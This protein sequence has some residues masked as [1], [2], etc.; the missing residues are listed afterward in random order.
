MARA[1]LG[2]TV[3]SATLRHR[4]QQA[5]ELGGWN[6]RS[7]WYVPAVDAVCESVCDDLDPFAAAERLGHDRARAGVSLGEALA[8]IDALVVQ[9]PGDRGAVLQRALSLGWADETLAP[10]ALV[11]DPLS[12]LAVAEYLQVR[13]DEVYRAAEVIGRSV[14]E[15]KALV[16]VRLDLR[17]RSGWGRSLPMV[18]AADCMRTVFDS[19]QS[20]VMLSDSVAVVL[21]DRE[22]TLARR[23]RVLA[24]MIANQ[25]RIDP[26]AA[27]PPPEV[28]IEPLPAGY[29]AAL[30]LVRDLDR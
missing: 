30:Q 27:V 12:G 2:G 26:Q 7:D 17:G 5:S 1:T 14:S 3:T 16:V 4:W 19:G 18:L 22:S 24:D 29:P 28:W 9:V 13:L 25:V 8:D 10:A 20:L 21:S 15:I 23:A 6:Y 11:T